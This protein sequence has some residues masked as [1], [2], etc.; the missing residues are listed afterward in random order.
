[1]DTWISPKAKDKQFAKFCIVLLRSSLILPKSQVLRI[2]VNDGV[3]VSYTIQENLLSQYHL[4]GNKTSVKY[5]L[6]ERWAKF[7]SE[8][9]KR[10]STD[11]VSE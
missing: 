10:A 2:F 8:N 11:K 9:F 7:T 6:S 5:L 4:P 3:T 1:M